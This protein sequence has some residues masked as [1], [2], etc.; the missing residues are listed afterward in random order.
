M[1]SVLFLS[2][3]KRTWKLPS[4]LTVKCYFVFQREMVSDFITCPTSCGYH[5]VLIHWFHGQTQAHGNIFYMFFA[6]CYFNLIVWS[7]HASRLCD[8]TSLLYWD[9]TSYSRTQSEGENIVQEPLPWI[10]WGKWKLVFCI[11]WVFTLLLHSSWQMISE[12][13]LGCCDSATSIIVI[14]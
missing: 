8:W 1:F 13:L 12:W 7:L 11:Q 2:E 14:I 6:K 3:H 4:M 9:L 5:R 10:H